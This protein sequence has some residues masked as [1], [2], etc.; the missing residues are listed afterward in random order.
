M[1]ILTPHL[2]HTF[3]AALVAASVLLAAGTAH[4]ES[5]NC[6]QFVQQNTSLGLHGDAYRWWD[7]AN[8]QYGRGNQ[9]KSGAVIVFSKTGILP[10][11]HV[12]VVRHQADKRTIIVDHANWSPINGRRGQVEKAVKIIDVSKHNDWSRVRVWYE[13]T[14][15]IG[16][17]VYPVKGFVYPARAH[18]HGR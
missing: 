18:P 10:H 17:T 6:V 2:R 12:A 3:S 7:A 13:P 15:E 1:R 14:A 16:Q 11:G 9:P 4:A 8:G 5:L